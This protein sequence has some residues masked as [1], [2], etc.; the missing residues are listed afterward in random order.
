VKVNGRKTDVEWDSQFN[1]LSVT[2]TL[3]PSEELKLKIKLKK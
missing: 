3:E 1:K 2:G